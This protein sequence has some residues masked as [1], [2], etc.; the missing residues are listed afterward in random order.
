M[1]NTGNAMTDMNRILVIGGGV[2]GLTVAI[3]AAEAGCDV[4]LVEKSTYLG[5]RVAS[6]KQYFPK[7]CPPAC[8]LEI[9]FKRI[10]QN[11]RVSVF[12]LA[13][14]ERVRGG[15]GNYT[16]DVKVEP[17]FVTEACTACG[18]C[19]AACPV[20]T[21][22]AFNLGMV[23]H[24]A[25]HLPHTAAYPARYVIER[26]SCKGGCH[27][28]ADACKYGAIDLNQQAVTKTFHV[29]AIVAATGWA[30]YDAVKIDNLGFGRCANV[31]TNV[32]L[33]RLASGSGPSAGHV[34]R[35][36]DGKEPK[37]VAFV[38]CAG[39]RDQ[40]H[41]PYCSGVCCSASLKHA[42]YIRSLYPDAKITIFYIDVR[43]PGHLQDFYNT[44]T[45]ENAIELIKGKVGK[46]E[47]DP[48]SRN[49]IVTAE[50]AVHGTKLTR[51]Y[52]LVVL[53][54]GIV[55]QTHD[56]PAVFATDEFGFI[57]NGQAGVYATGCV[58][59]PTEVS[60]V[61]R[62]ATGAALRALQVAR[63]GANHG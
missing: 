40:N 17:R 30:P 60:A 48:E 25:I 6:F 36:S 37:S 54:T 5:G 32:M 62:D 52:D 28:C 43:T 50:D 29:A 8:G 42:T 14:V 59:R 3:E 4:V 63:R 15:P 12:T 58:T 44:V 39:S 49:L 7:L 13:Q 34:L 11:P 46:V 47:E 53:A 20:D 22:D 26:S 10:R 16:V 18:D 57:T 45:A 2:A 33:E 27:A 24:K 41:L 19:T 21:P 9:N 51:N 38:Q 61:I 1:G 55:P 35:P 23:K 31:V 56:L